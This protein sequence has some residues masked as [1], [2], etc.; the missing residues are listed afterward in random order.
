M[1]DRADILAGILWDYHHLNQS[2]KISDCILVMCSHDLRVADYAAKLFLDGWAPLLVFSGGIAHIGD[3][4]ETGWE[5]SEAEMFADRAEI[6]GVPKDRILRETRASN[7]GENITFSDELLKKNGRNPDSF[8]IVQK[9][10][11]ERRAFATVKAQRPNWDFVVTSPVI[12]IDEYP[13]PEQGI[14]KDKLINI[15]VGDLQRIRDYPAKGFQ[16]PQEIPPE[17]IG[18]FNELLRQGYG[19]HI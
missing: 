4:L 17:V 15:L 13:D 6:A 5:K 16:I 14:D 18:A 19:R 7:S 3:M 8:I 9:P 10:Y 11:M 12:S 1:A 2:I